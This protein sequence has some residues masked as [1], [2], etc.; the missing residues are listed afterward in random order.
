LWLRKRLSNKEVVGNQLV[1]LS[2]CEPAGG[3][4]SGGADV[5]MAK[6]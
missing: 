5:D 4:I 6:K 3:C 1:R 2:D